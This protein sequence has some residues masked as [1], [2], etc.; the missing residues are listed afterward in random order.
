MSE[1][2]TFQKPAVKVQP[3]SDSERL[4]SIFLVYVQPVKINEEGKPVFPKE[5]FLGLQDI[6][7][8]TGPAAKKHMEESIAK[9]ESFIENNRRKIADILVDEANV[10]IQ[11][12]PDEE[13]RTKV[14]FETREI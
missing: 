11:L 10:E 4:V 6:F 13:L 5:A 14:R 7:K 3:K 9:G 2:K 12:N 8:K 1:A